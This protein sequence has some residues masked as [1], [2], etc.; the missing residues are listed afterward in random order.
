MRAFQAPVVRTQTTY[1]CGGVQCDKAQ[2]RNDSACLLL[3]NNTKMSCIYR[4]I[5]SDAE[6][7]LSADQEEEAAAEE[8]SG[9]EICVSQLHAI[10]GSYSATFDST[11]TMIKASCKKDDEIHIC[12]PA[13]ENVPQS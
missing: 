12:L 6:N 2:D 7:E 9:M 4:T 1:W 13:F 10:C 8:P 11:K 5:K 3:P